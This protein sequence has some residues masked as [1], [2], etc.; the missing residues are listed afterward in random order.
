MIIFNILQFDF[1]SITVSGIFVVGKLE[2]EDTNS[3]DILQV[4]V[5]FPLRCLLANRG[6][7]VIDTTVLEISL[8][9]FLHLH[10][11]TT[12]I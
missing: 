10:D 11:E 6:G 2:I 12:A 8:L 4:V 9:R 5:P 7:G 3:I 1:V